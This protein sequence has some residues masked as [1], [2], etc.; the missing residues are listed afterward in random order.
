MPE[1]AAKEAAMHGILNVS[2]WFMIFKRIFANELNLN[3]IASENIKQNVKIR[4]KGML[5]KKQ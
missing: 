1:E 4:K 2:K 5:C 3:E